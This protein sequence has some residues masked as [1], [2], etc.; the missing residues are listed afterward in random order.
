MI[1][2]LHSDFPTAVRQNELHSLARSFAPNEVIGAIWTSEMG[3]IAL[4]RV[5]SI[6]REL[7]VL[8]YRTIAIEDIGFLGENNGYERFDFCRYAYCTLTWNY[9]NA[10]GGG[11]A[12]DGKLTA[13]GRAAI[14]AMLGAGCA[15]DVAHL[16]RRTF[17]EAVEASNRVICSHT[18]F[19]SHFRS[20]D[21]SQVKLLIERGAPI[22]LACVRAFTD[23]VDISSFA[24]VI[25][26]FCQKYGCD[27]LCI[28]TDYFGSTDIPPDM[29]DYQKLS[30]VGDTLFSYGY[31]TQDIDK[32]FYGNAKT[33]FTTET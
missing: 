3:D 7:L 30:K 16:N 12:D 25:D 9:N 20:L 8:G 23:A 11:A 13:A 14:K 1:F 22:G 10:F 6:T 28:G 21:D 26:M 24:R 31:R 19:N 18:G 15:L 27:N 17:F 5:E 2:D 33:F 29:D 32:I 4:Y